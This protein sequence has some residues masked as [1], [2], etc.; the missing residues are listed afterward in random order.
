MNRSPL[1]HGRIVESS[2]P[3]AIKAS[4]NAMVTEFLAAA[5]EETPPSPQMEAGA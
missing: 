5:S 1:S 4:H 3:A 2:S